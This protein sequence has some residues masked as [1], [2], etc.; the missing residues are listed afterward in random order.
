ME[1]FVI[2]ERFH[3]LKICLL[4]CPENSR[5]AADCP[6]GTVDFLLASM[7]VNVRDDLLSTFCDREAAAVD[8]VADLK[9]ELG[10]WKSHL[11]TED[12]S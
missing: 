9:R 4:T 3:A 6:G 1:L 7:A 8:E 10:E 5:C 11:E 2:V 12:V